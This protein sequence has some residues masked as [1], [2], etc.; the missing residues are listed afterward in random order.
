MNSKTAF[1]YQSE[2]YMA[3]R[4]M[5]FYTCICMQLV[6]FYFPYLPFASTYK[7]IHLKCCKCNKHCLVLAILF[8]SKTSLFHQRAYV[9]RS[10]YI[11]FIRTLSAPCYHSQ[12]ID[13]KQVLSVLPP[14]WLK[15]H[16]IAWK[17]WYEMP[18]AYWI[19]LSPHVSN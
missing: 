16:V 19:T 4:N 12:S 14:R 9:C 5:S 17:P 2:K 8:N 10:K 7:V 15:L 3:G 6:L 1:I 13:I 11:I 18:M